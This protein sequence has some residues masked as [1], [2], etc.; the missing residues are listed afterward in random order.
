MTLPLPEI[1]LKNLQAE[2]LL[3]DDRQTRLVLGFSG[4]LDST[5]LLH[6]LGS[7]RAERPLTL[8]AA[9]FD[10]GW[11]ES[12]LDELP[13]LHQHCARLKV[14]LVMIPAD[15]RLPRTEAAAREARYESLLR[16]ARDVGAHALL[17]AHQA[18]DQIETLLFRLFRGSGI[19]G[20]SGIQKRLNVF[21]ELSA[22]PV[23]RPMLDVSREDVRRYAE[24][25]HLQYFRD[26]TNSQSRYQ[27]NMIRNEAL[28]FLRE[29]FPQIDDALLRLRDVCE[30]D[31][32]ILRDKMEDVWQRVFYAEDGGSLDAIA[33]N[34]LARPYQRR[35]VKRFLTL[36]RL[37]P[38]FHRIEDVIDFIE[39]E[40][41]RNLSS[42]LMSLEKPHLEKLHTA[43]SSVTGGATPAGGGESRFLSLYKHRISVVSSNRLNR[44][45][46]GE[47]PEALIETPVQ[48]PGEYALA[49]L[50]LRVRIDELTEQ[51]RA[52]QGLLR[53]EQSLEAYV[54][55][56]EFR[57]RPLT[58]RTRRP[59]DRIHPF[60]MSGPMR[61]KNYFINRGVPRFE[62]DRT[63]LLTYGQDV[64]WVAGVGVCE[65]LRV[66][67]RP[68]HRLQLEREPAADATA[69]ASASP[70]PS[71]SAD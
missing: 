48:G 26:P 28:P 55:L 42:A 53:P 31:L 61:L 65:Q 12:L 10:H 51:E 62:R 29:R 22:P 67:G 16:L 24:Q 4:G 25:H 15:R 34:Q 36:H 1:V 57:D 35:I 60:G 13:L 64:L 45:Q 56:A 59:G 50:G 20:L 9:Y 5:V 14:P 11:R 27:R 33:F 44:P 69:D 6:A 38:D 58:L 43:E 47:E 21:Q 3:R 70:V 39:G 68:T 17:T 30:G 19:E 54:D 32:T 52:A 41:R 37:E 49:E 71:S 66:Q 8:T 23:L 7:L 40:N 18:D 2:G 63:L 46:E